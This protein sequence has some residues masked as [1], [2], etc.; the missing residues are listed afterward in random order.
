VDS[1][2]GEMKDVS[3]YPYL[4]AELLSRG[5]S[6]PDLEKLAFYNFYR[7]FKAAEQVE[8]FQCISISFMCAA[9][10]YVQCIIPL[11]EKRGEQHVFSI[12][13]MSYT[14]KKMVFL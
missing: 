8:R 4:F 9:A 3:T 1:H 10:V 2:V 12:I 13:I 5:W 14:I 6:R 7:V 11:I